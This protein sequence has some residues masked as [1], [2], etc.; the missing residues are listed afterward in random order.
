MYARL[1]LTSLAFQSAAL[2]TELPGLEN[3]QYSKKHCPISLAVA[4]VCVANFGGI[5]Q[6]SRIFTLRLWLFDG[7]ELDHF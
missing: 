3:M 5:A 2:P 4:K 1:V 7:L 6:V